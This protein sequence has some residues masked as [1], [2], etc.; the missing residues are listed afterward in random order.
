MSLI[1]VDLNNVRKQRNQNTNPKISDAFFLNSCRLRDNHDRAEGA[2]ETVDNLNTIW[3]HV[4][5]IYLPVNQAKLLTYN[6]T[7]G[8]VYERR[9]ITQPVSKL[10]LRTLQ[11]R[12]VVGRE[13]ALFL[14]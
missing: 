4:G 12:S 11:P 6:L 10:S 3:R 8:R 7:C 13:R 14:F 9:E 1:L 2:K 5:A